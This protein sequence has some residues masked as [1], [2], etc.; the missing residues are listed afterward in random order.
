MAD[1]KVFAIAVATA[2]CKEQDPTIVR[3]QQKDMWP[4]NPKVK[5]DSFSKERRLQ[6]RPWS[7]EKI[8]VYATRCVCRKW[9]KLLNDPPSAVCVLQR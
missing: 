6:R 4:P 1:S 7:C 9:Q 2:L 8:V 3:W 5:V